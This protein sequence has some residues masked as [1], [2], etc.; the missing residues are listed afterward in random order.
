MSL[1]VHGLVRLHVLHT[2][3]EAR[4]LRHDVNGPTGTTTSAAAESV[5]YRKV[6][7]APGAIDQKR[8]DKESRPKTVLD[9][10]LRSAFRCIGENISILRGDL[11]SAAIVQLPCSMTERFSLTRRSVLFFSKLAP[12]DCRLRNW[13]QRKLQLQLG[14]IGCDLI[15]LCQCSRPC[16]YY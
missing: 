7:K 11:T 5:R 3:P 6:L 2:A 10:L 15:S 14:P 9:K 1:H 4:A 12:S 8:A 16:H 13:F